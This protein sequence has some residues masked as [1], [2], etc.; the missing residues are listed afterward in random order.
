MDDFC[1]KSKR[2]LM[3]TFVVTVGILMLAGAILWILSLEGIVQ[4]SWAGIFGVIFTFLG[5]LWALLQWYAQLRE[6]RA[7]NMAPTISVFSGSPT[8]DHRHSQAESIPSSNIVFSPLAETLSPSTE[9]HSVIDNHLTI[10]V[11][12]PSMINEN[13]CNMYFDRRYRIVYIH[14]CHIDI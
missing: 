2:A 1:W 12:K 9:L 14:I 3:L 8:Q 5:V 11:K 4:G 6:Q 13:D 10:V 7:I